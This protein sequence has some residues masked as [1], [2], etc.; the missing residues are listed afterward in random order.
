MLSFSQQRIAEH[1][2][3]L[4]DP[5]SNKAKNFTWGQVMQVL[6][7]MKEEFETYSG[8]IYGKARL[9]H[10]FLILLLFCSACPSRNVDIMRLRIA[11]DK[12]PDMRVQGTMEDNYLVFYKDGG[13]KLIT[14]NFK[15]KTKYG[16][17][18]IDI[19]EADY[20]E[21][22]LRQYKSK[23]R[24]RLMSGK[25]HDFLFMRSSGD[26]FLTSESFTVYLRKT[27][28]KFTD[29]LSF[30]T[31]TLRKALVNWLYEEKKDDELKAAVA[32]LMSHSSRVQRLR[33]YTKEN[34]HK[35][36]T[37]VSHLS[38]TTAATLGTKR[39]APFE[40]KEDRRPLQDQ[41]VALLAGEST[42]KKP[43]VLL[44]KVLAVDYERQVV[45][46]SELEET[47]Q[48]G[49]YRMNIGTWF[50]EELQSIVS[51]IDV[52][53]QDGTNMYVLRTPKREIHTYV[54]KGM[55]TAAAADD[56]ADTAW[57]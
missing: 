16:V 11:Y 8:N 4:E 53:Y 17:N 45:A 46:M 26:P 49:K 52:N 34:E 29:G 48:P 3:K 43:R 33:Y 18:R 21:Y 35:M 9:H 38:N 50:E 44:G 2:K 1:E 51:P 54:R 10:D 56:E 14:F 37:G 28:E 24:Q 5:N 30:T 15:T 57:I 19:S 6:R 41:V 12:E 13:V 23:H 39:S 55:E 40:K 20:L 47:D 25:E 7:R 27:F 32:R 36:K 31:T 42:L 22:H